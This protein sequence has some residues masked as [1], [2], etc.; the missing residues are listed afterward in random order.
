MSSQIFDMELIYDFCKHVY[1]VVEYKFTQFNNI[2]LLL[3]DVYI[4]ALSSEGLKLTV[5]PHQ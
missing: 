3:I 4:M 2:Y 5:V 1:L